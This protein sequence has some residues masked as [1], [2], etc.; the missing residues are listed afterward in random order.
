M[1]DLCEFEELYARLEDIKK[2]AVRGEVG[3][4]AFLSPRESHYASIYLKQSGAQFFLYGGYR[5]A[6]RKRMYILPSYM[7]GISSVKELAEYDIDSATVAVRAKGSGFCRLAHKDFMGSLLGLGID[8]SVIG[9]I[10]TLSDNEA[11]VI[12]DL[13]ISDFLINE[14]Y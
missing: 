14:C 2:R 13:K 1:K 5:D 8:R 12:C 3:I 10:I 9:D 4:S 11:L 6:E 7:E